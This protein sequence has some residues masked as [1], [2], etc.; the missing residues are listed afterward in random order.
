MM[1]TSNRLLLA[2]QDMQMQHALE[3]ILTNVKQRKKVEETTNVRYQPQDCSNLISMAKTTESP[4]S[5]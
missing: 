2:E 1:P 3:F 4:Q 5:V